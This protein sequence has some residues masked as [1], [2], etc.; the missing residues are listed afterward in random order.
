MTNTVTSRYECD[1]LVL[2]DF[3]SLLWCFLL[4]G[5]VI[6]QKSLKQQMNILLVS[7]IHLANQAIEKLQKHL[8]TTKIDA[9]ILSGDICNLKGA[10]YTDEQCLKKAEQDIDNIVQ[11]LQMICEKVYFIPGN[12][13]PLSSF[14]QNTIPHGVN[15]HNTA[16]QLADGLVIAGFGGSVPAFYDESRGNQLVW[17]GY[18]FT[19]E[20]EYEK[21]FVPFIN[22]KVLSSESSVLL[23]THVGPHQSDTVKVRRRNSEP[24]EKPYYIIYSG[25]ATVQKQLERTELQDKVVLNVHGHTH[26]SKGSTMLDQIPVVNAGSLKEGN[27][28]IVTLARRD[29]SVSNSWFVKGVQLY[30]LVL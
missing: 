19:T 21:E 25:S 12:H 27:W 20:D 13:D 3:L 24:T 17:E 18:P 26:D 30:H 4:R 2:C 6:L 11:A 28:G 9:I 29:E 5:V 14:E 15:I 10:E 23:V 1:A 7:D 22:Q 16:I 8:S